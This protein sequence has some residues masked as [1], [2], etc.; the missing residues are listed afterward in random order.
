M[1]HWCATHPRYSA[2]RQPNSLCGDCWKLWFLR[3]PEEKERL[4]DTYREA[5]ALRADLTQT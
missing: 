1:S 2:K 3:N 5:E 4:T